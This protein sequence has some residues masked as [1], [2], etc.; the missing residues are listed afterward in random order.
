MPQPKGKDCQTGQK[1]QE[2][3]I[4]C[5]QKVHVK[6]KDT[7]KLK[8]RGRKKTYHANTNH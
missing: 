8:V 3:T 4:C 1:K 5:L 7:D 2:P 6:Y